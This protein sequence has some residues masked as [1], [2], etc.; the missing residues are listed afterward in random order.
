MNI[1]SDDSWV[2]NCTEFNLTKSTNS[3]E[4]IF[5][6]EPENT[7]VCRYIVSEHIYS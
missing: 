6:F 5:D 4:N 2:M 3:I 7:A 1:S